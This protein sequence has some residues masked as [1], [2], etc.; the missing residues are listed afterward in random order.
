MHGK[1]LS[2]WEGGEDESEGKRLAIEKKRNSRHDKQ[3][4]ELLHNTNMQRCILNNMESVCVRVCVRV[5]NPWGSLGHC[6]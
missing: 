5:F 3:K 6:S 4:A 2:P 1:A